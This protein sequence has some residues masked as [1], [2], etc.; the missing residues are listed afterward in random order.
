MSEKRTF[1]PPVFTGREPIP[2]RI[3]DLTPIDKADFRITDAN[4]TDV[5][6]LIDDDPQ[7]EWESASGKCTLTIDMAKVRSIAALGNYATFVE[8]PVPPPKDVGM[9]QGLLE[10]VFPTDFVISLSTDGENYEEVAR[11]VFRSFA[12]EEIIRFAPQ[13]ARYVKFEILSTTGQRLGR[14]PFDTLPLK[15]CEISLFE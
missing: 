3:D 8:T 6:M 12:G 9:V 2:Y 14:S 1:S 7:T 15:L 10:G 5:S 13:K 11:G 4:G